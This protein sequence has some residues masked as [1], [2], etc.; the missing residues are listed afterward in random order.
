[1]HVH[2]QSDCVAPVFRSRSSSSGCLCSGNSSV[3]MALIIVPRYTARTRESGWL[4]HP[5]SH[6]PN[7]PARAL[8]TSP[9]RLSS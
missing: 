9:A 3:P 5:V 4:Q 6:P 8:A 7:C 2:L 1:L